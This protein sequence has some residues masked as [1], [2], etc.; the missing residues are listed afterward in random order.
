MTETVGQTIDAKVAALETKL[1][2]IEAAGK[3][4][5]AKVKAWAKANWGHLVLTWP[6]SVAVLAPIVKAVLKL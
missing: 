3:T 1:A 4:D 5:L 2:A 6:A